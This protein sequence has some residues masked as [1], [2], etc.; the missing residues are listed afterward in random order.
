MVQEA[1]QLPPEQ[2]PPQAERDQD[3]PQL[4]VVAG[5]LIAVLADG[6]ARRKLAQGLVASNNDVR[7]LVRARLAGEPFPDLPLTRGWRAE[8]VLPD[9][10][11]VLEGRKLVGVQDVAAEAPLALRDAD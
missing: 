10:V 4:A 8:H 6:C 1:R 3:P 7:E 2:C 11:G 9:L 5:V